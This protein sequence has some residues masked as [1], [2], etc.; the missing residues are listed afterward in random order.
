MKHRID[1]LNSMD[2]IHKITVRTLQNAYTFYE[3][4]GFELFE[5]KKDFWAEGFDYNMVYKR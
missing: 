4:Q 1:K 5:I 3:K 2:R